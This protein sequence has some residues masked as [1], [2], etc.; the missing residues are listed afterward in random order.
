MQAVVSGCVLIGPERLQING[1][2]V[3]R[4]RGE[5]LPGDEPALMPQR[6]QLRYPVAIPRDGA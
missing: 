5:F 1:R 2:A 4:H 3:A 6:N